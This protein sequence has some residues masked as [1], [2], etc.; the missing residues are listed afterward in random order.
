MQA[1]AYCGGCHRYELMVEEINEM[2][3]R[4]QERIGDES[5]APPGRPS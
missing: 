1:G 2:L 3:D 4:V 5:D